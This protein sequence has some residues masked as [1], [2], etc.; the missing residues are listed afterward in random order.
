MRGSIHPSPTGKMKLLKR[1]INGK[2]GDGMVSLMAQEPED[3]WHVYNLL[4]PGDTVKASTVRKVRL[5]GV[6]RQRPP[7]HGTDNGAHVPFP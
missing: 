1:S 3:M 7:A 5:P 6:R 2:D 4:A